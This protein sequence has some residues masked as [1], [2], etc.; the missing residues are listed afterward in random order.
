[1][2]SPTSTRRSA[3]E[4][5]AQQWDN[6]GR[7]FAEGFLI[8]RIVAEPSRHELAVSSELDKRLRAPGGF[9]GTSMH[10]ANWELAAFPLRRYRAVAGL[11]QELSNPLADA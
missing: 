11:Y 2:P 4:I 8:D 9:I 7:T 3:S 6:L 5:A 10:A 1:M